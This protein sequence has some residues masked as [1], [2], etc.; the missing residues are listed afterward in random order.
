MALEALKVFLVIGL[1]ALAAVISSD[2][3]KLPLALRGLKKILA[4]D[5]GEKN[6]ASPEKV[7]PSGLK[8]FIAFLLVVAAIA[9]A[10][11]PVA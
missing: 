1:L 11:W 5:R 10:L 6:A 8:R 4:A 3:G 7:R 9:I 2:K